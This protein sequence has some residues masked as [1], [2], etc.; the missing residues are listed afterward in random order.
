M[1]TRRSALFCDA[2]RNRVERFLSPPGQHNARAF[3][4][5]RKRS[6]LADSASRPLT[7]AI[8]PVSRR[9][10]APPSDMVIL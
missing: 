7:H 2:S 8:L 9:I 3:P 6:G 1:D 5:E 4:G 10:N